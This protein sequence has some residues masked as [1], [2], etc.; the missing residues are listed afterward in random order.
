VVDGRPG[1]TLALEAEL[2]GG[3]HVR[4]AGVDEAGRGPLAGPVSA[5]A[6]ILDPARPIAGL[7]DSKALKP[8]Q[9]EA[10]FPLILARATVAFAFLTARDIDAG[11]I[12]KASLEAMRRAVAALAVAPD[13]VLI[14]GRDVPPGLCCPARAVIG[15]DG[16]S[17]SIAAASIVAKVMRDR[18]MTRAD[19]AF[20]GYDFARHA[21]YGT[22]LHRRAIAVLGPSPL[23]R[24]SFA[25]FRNGTD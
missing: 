13:F 24:L 8:A 19:A 2:A 7:D 17:A 25:P 11:D 3:G 21:G 23:H 5:A 22:V 12:R 20:P 6:V 14:D 10:L 1:A 9:R 15:G 18:L 16:I 4:I